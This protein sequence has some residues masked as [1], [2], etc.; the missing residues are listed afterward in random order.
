MKYC[1]KCNERY[2]EEIIHFC[3]KDGT[4][5]IEEAEPKFSALP[6]EHIE[7]ADIGEQTVIRRRPEAEIPQRPEGRSERIVIPTTQPEPQVIRQR[8]TA[9]A[10]YPPPKANTAKTVVLTILGTLFVLACGAGLFWALQK[11]RSA[12]AN[13]SNLNANQNVN[14]NSNIGFDPNF[15]FNAPTPGSN[16]TIPNLN[17]NLNTNAKTPTPTPKPSPSSTPSPSPA[18]SPS[19]SPSAT[20]NRSPTPRPS[21]TPTPR[22]GPR[23]PTLSNRPVNGN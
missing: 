6:S 17:L 5:L 4:P 11:D 7:D 15:N 18:A 20:P 16:I 8:Q 1:P 2:D 19:G 12:N 23:P 10:Y 9:A 21:P 13:N 22:T 14:L 3:T